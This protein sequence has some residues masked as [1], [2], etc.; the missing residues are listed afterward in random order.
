M[1]H[2][3]TNI[4]YSLYILSKESSVPYRIIRGQRREYPKPLYPINELRD[5]GIES[6]VTTHYL[7]LDISVILSDNTYRAIQKNKVLLSSYKNVLLLPILQQSNQIKLLFNQDSK[8]S[9]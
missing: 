5:M 3:R 4:I 2:N 7:L 8:T 6:I 1:K 9:E